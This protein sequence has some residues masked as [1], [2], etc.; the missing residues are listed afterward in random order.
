MSKDIKRIEK[1][2]TTNG[3]EQGDSNDIYIHGFSIPNDQTIETISQSIFNEGLKKSSANDSILSTVSLLNPDND[4]S[5]QI[6]KYSYKGFNKV[7]VKIPQELENLYLGNCKPKYN[8]S[9]GNQYEHNCVLDYLDFENIPTE[10]IV[11]I[12]YPQNPVIEDGESHNYVFYENP[13]YYDHPKNKDKN[14]ESIVNK[15]NDK[16]KDDITLAKEIILG[17]EIS[18]KQRDFLKHIGK[19]DILYFFDQRDQYYNS[20]IDLNDLII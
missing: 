20:K 13:N 12:I 11:G 4:L 3:I 10:F 6:E 14:I 19:T 5:E 7:I 9:T 16:L 15:I 17:D 1:F 18:D 2:L 8:D